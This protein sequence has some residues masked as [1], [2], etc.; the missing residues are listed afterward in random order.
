MKNLKL[1]GLVIV[2][3]FAGYGLC[4]FTIV[5]SQNKMIMEAINKN[6]TAITNTFDKIKTSKG[7]IGLD[8]Y[9]EIQPD[10]VMKRGFIH[11]IFNNKN[12]KK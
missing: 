11:S 7:T 9:N 8:L 3:I 10:S 1:I 2:L 12:K 6:T 4:Y 5:R